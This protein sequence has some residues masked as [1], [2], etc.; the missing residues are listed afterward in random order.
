MGDPDQSLFVFL[1]INYILVLCISA[2][3]LKGSGRIVNGTEAGEN[4]FPWMCSVNYNDNSVSDQNPCIIFNFLCSSLA[5]V[6][7]F[8]V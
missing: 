6:P 5:A 4:E 8:A 7:P 2:C 1:C 3:G